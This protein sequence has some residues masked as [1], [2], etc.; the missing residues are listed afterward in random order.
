MSN[1]DDEWGIGEKMEGYEL[2]NGFHRIFAD[3]NHSTVRLQFGGSKGT[4]LEFSK[5]EA[6]FIAGKLKEFAESL[7]E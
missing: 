1:K 5:S 3:Y 7:E 4:A 2:N 6:I